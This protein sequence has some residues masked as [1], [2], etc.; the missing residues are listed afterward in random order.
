M[1][2]LRISSTLNLHSYPK[3]DVA[4]YVRAG[5]AFMKRNGF[6]AMDFPMGLMKTVQGSGSEIIDAAREASETEGIRFEVCHLPFSTKIGQDAAFDA[7]FSAD[8]LRCM[9]AAKRLGVD[10]AVLHPN[11]TTVPAE[12]FNRQAEYD[13][14]M[15]HLAPFADYA[16]KIG[17]N[18]VVENMRQ[19]PQHY[20]V[21]RFCGTPEELCGIADALGIGVCWDF[22]HAHINGLKQSEAL[23]YVGN[24]LKVLHVNDNV[25]WGDDHVPPF[26][27]TVDWKDAMQGLS[28]IGF[29]GLFN[30]EITAGRHPSDTRDAFA[31]YL[32]CEARVIMG[33]M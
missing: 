2:K 9:D 20:P 17:V 29:N 5:V 25:A 15:A 30:Y 3:E 13:S 23:V 7:R 4:A 18:I 26:C 8:M 21:H 14:V 27:G 10:Y 19:V 12:N 22:G 32:L 33:F 11:T 31:Q 6:D 24:R 28:A 16:A 1:A